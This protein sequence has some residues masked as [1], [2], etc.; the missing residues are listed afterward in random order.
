MENVRNSVRKTSQKLKSGMGA[1]DF[2]GLVRK[3][4]NA[5]SGSPRLG[6]GKSPGEEN[7]RFGQAPFLNFPA[8]DIAEIIEGGKRAGVD[9]TIIVYFFGLLGVNGPMPLEFTNYVFRRSHN[10]SDNTWRRFLDIIHH[11]FLS[12]YYRA[13][14]A[15]QQ[16]ISFDRNNDDPI[17]G[18]VKSL[19]GLPPGHTERQER[20]VLNSAQHFSFAV[21]NRWGL[22]DLLR[23]T[24]TFNLEVQEFVPVSYDIPPDNYAILGNAQSSTLGVNLQIGRTYMS[25]TGNF[26]IHIGPI[27]FEEYM[28]F[29]S[30]QNG[31]DLL[32]D[33]VNLYLDRP[34]DYSVVFSV[35]RNTIPLAQLGFDLEEGRWD[36]PQLGYT[37]WIGNPDERVV[38]LTIAA[39]R[40]NRSRHKE[41]NYG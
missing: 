20:V 10:Y 32:T 16:A 31:F 34:L 1:P 17:T 5:N 36:P 2:W 25:I 15:H 3:I 27:S 19:A 21:K 8:A 18:I 23:R 24:F 41:R 29:M 35:V 13:Y 38:K 22:E 26:E 40:L 33:A 11:R 9:A 14:A 6:H 4:E 28:E 37:S 7:L 39:A 12:L 30:G